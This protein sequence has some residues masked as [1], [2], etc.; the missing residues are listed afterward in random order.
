VIQLNNTQ[1]GDFATGLNY[2]TKSVGAIS[3]RLFGL[4]ESYFQTFS[5]VKAGR[6]T[7][8]LTDDQSVPSQA[9]GGSAQWSRPVGRMQTLVAGFEA[10]R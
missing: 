6:D 5:T 9:L 2:E 4:Y 7:E 3:A 1:L 10:A 8:T